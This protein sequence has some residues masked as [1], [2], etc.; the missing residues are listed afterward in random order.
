MKRWNPLDPFT[1]APVTVLFHSL[2]L[3]AGRFGQRLTLISAHAHR[4]IP[5]R[6]IVKQAELKLHDARAEREQHIMLPFILKFQRNRSSK[7][8][9]DNL[10]VR[11][12]AFRASKAEYSSRP[13][14]VQ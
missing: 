13:S 4:I 7:T 9:V 11:P 8:G 1:Q 10:T 6:I 3:F 2:S 14:S 5:F 12:A